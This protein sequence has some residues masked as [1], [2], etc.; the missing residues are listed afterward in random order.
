MKLALDPAQLAIL[1]KKF[2]SS[3][4]QKSKFGEE[5]RSKFY[6]LGKYG[7]YVFRVMP[8]TADQGNFFGKFI[9]NH[10]IKFNDDERCTVVPCVE[11]YNVPDAICPVCEAMRELQNS[12]VDIDGFWRLR[13]NMQ[14]AMK[15]L[16]LEAPNEDDFPM[17]KISFFKVSQPVF[18][19]MV[20]IYN[21]PDSPDI[22]D[23]DVGVAWVV[24]R[25]E[26]EKHWNVK[27]LDSSMPQCG[28]LG[29]SE[30][31]KQALLDA[32]SNTDLNK[33]FKIPTDEKMMQIKEVAKTVK[34]KILRAKGAVEESVNSVAAEAISP[35]PQPVAVSV[36]IV[37]PLQQTVPVAQKAQ[38]V[39][40]QA[41][42]QPTAEPTFMPPA[43]TVS[44]M[45]N[46]VEDDEIPFETQTT[47]EK[48]AEP[49]KQAET[50]QSVNIDY[51]NL[52][53]QQLAIMNQYRDAC[54]KECFGHHDKYDIINNYDCLCDPYS[55]NCALCIKAL[56]GI[57]HT[58]DFGGV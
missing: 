1:N 53:P 33:I 49:V 16:M 15:V 6:S 51:N 7:R 32:N 57:D 54:K 26:K 4:N 5:D 14:V 39:P 58:K 12:G 23:P 52:T 47:V 3:S 29:G 50:V 27:L 45:P 18:Q 31:N 40:V 30:A 34:E 55:S 44:L 46:V 42:P 25:G 11:Q 43:Q 41:A 20:A 10:F 24:S 2:E 17:N 48:V 21:S 38:P 28:I 22:L 19:Q 36:P 9:G 37:N 56:T 35:E 8:M 13:S